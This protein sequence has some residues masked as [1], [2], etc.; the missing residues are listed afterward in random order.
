MGGELTSFARAFSCWMMRLKSESP[1]HKASIYFLG[2]VKCPFGRKTF[3][4]SFSITSCPTLCECITRCT[5]PNDKGRKLCCTSFC[6]TLRVWVVCSQLW[7]RDFRPAALDLIEMRQCSKNKQSLVIFNWLPIFVSWDC[8][9]EGSWEWGRTLKYI[10]QRKI[11]L[12]FRQSAPS[13]CISDRW[14]EPQCLV[15]SFGITQRHLAVRCGEEKDQ[16]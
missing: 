4:V 14:A 3:E 10:Y 1:M 2:H 15:P 6:T 11:L 7:L 5:L 16:S 9:G 13:G 8:V 12:L